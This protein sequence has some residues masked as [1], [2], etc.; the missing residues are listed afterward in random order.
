MLAA[1]LKN[2]KGQHTILRADGQQHTYVKVCS[3][4]VNG[5]LRRAKR[6]TQ[7]TR[8][9]E[10]SLKGLALIVMVIIMCLADNLM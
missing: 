9:L 2:K 7:E 8:D 4:K 10:N 3:L 6:K 1:I 5:K